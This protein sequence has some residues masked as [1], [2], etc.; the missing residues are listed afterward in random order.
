MRAVI[1][2]WLQQLA[3]APDLRTVTLQHIADH[4]P[5]NRM[6]CRRL[7][8]QIEKITERVLGAFQARPLILKLVHEPAKSAVFM[9]IFRQHSHEGIR[10]V[11]FKAIT[12]PSAGDV[13]TLRENIMTRF[14][15]VFMGQALHIGFLR[16]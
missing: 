5:D 13:V 7:L 3:P 9:L 11:I 4:L 1:D 16:P 15:E 14:Q 6:T 12:E 10:I 2:A 8:L